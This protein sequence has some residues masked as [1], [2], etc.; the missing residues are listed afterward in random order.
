MDTVFQIAGGFV[1]PFWA[2]MIFAPR[3]RFTLVSM[4]SA[5]PVLAL[6]GLYAVLVLPRVGALWAELA[7]PRLPGMTALLGSPEGATIGWV[8]FL[9]FDLFVGRWIY[10]DSRDRSFSPWVLGPVLLLTLMFGPL[11]L[12]AY[13]LLRLGAGKRKVEAEAET[14]SSSARREPGTE[15]AAL[16]RRIWEASPP[17]AVLTAVAMAASV[18][19]VAGVFLDPRVI[20]GAPAWLK[21]A[22]FLVSVSIYAATL[23][24]LLSHVRRPNRAAA[25]IGGIT[26]VSLAVELAIIALQAARGTISHYNMATPFDAALW[27]AMG[28][29][30]ML[31]WLAGAAAAVLLIRQPH[32]DRLLSTSL[33]LGLL[34]ALAGMAEG[35][36]MARSGAHSVGVPD[37]G[38]GL[39]VV[40]WSTV[41]GDLRIGHFLGLHAL[42]ALPLLAWLLTGASLS[43]GQRLGLLRLGGLAY[44]GLMAVLT[45]QALRGQPLIRPD[46]LTWTVLGGLGVTVLALASAILL[47]ESAW[48]PARGNVQSA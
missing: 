14:A 41:G 20:T 3:A 48:R 38:P 37:G 46:G 17:L 42:Q 45:W 22:K 9:A 26:T 11:G 24:W 12:V 31:V 43:E 32:T 29:F 44:G 47:R 13:S 8:H 27:N 40:G 18:P 2:A 4:R 25:W 33:K 19:A 21:P 6:A 36:L 23:A 15:A 34:L 30:I 28:G 16:A 10:L 39:P 7:Q 5:L 1:L 35:M